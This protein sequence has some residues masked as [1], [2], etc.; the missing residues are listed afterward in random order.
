MENAKN[1]HCSYLFSS[2]KHKNNLQLSGQ[3]NLNKKILVFSQGSKKCQS[4]ISYLA[5]ISKPSRN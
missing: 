1:L 3:H 5:R 4:W 2:R